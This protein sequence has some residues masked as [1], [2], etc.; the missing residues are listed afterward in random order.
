[1][2]NNTYSKEKKWIISC[3]Q[4]KIDPPTDLNLKEIIRICAFEGIGPL[5]YS[6]LKNNPFIPSFLLKNLKA[7][8][9]LSQTK[10]SIL[11]KEIENISYILAQ[12]NIYPIYLKGSALLLMNI[13]KD[14][15]HRPLSDID[16]LIEPDKILK[17]H[18]ILTKS[19]YKIVSMEY[20]KSVQMI[21][22]ERTYKKGII[23][24]DIHWPCQILPLFDA[25]KQATL[26][27]YKNTASYVP[28]IETFLLHILYHVVYSH[29]YPRL[30]W[31]VDISRVIQSYRINW[32]LFYNYTQ[33]FYFNGLFYSVLNKTKELF[34]IPIPEYLINVHQNILSNLLLKSNEEFPVL[35][36]FLRL[37]QIN[38]TKDKMI[39]FLYTLFPSTNFI[40]IRY[41]KKGKI[42]IAFSL[43]RPILIFFNALKNI[44][45]LLIMNIV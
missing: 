34:N 21:N 20:R 23:A 22:G 31:L 18:N 33:D 11:L 29:F 32:D 8:Y 12:E 26:I 5:L 28:N 45:R 10:N 40:S 17:V 4:Q 30:I 19:G 15:A 41:Q 24:I 27:H 6:I 44:L 43:I 25:V 2:K 9:I 36:Y 16:M 14:I 38:N 3:L 13:Y 35:S 37:I 1:M 7:Q 42:V 39:Y